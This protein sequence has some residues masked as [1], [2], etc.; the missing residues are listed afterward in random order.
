MQKK[1]TSFRN[2]ISTETRITILLTKQRFG[3]GQLLIEDLYGVAK[4]TVS[5]ILR[6]FCKAVRQHLQLFFF[7]M[8]TESHFRVLIREFEALHNIPY[9]IG[10]IDGSRILFV[11][12]M[13]GRDNYYCQKWFHSIIL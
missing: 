4:C 3:N 9:I 12:P 6:E 7:Q 1:Y 2:L 13:V 10:A 11:A 8:P 5:K